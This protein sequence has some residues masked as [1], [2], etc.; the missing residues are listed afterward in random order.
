MSKVINL[1]ESHVG[2]A[3]TSLFA[4]FLLDFLTDPRFKRC[5]PIIVDLDKRNPDVA[6]RYRSTC[7]TED[8]ISLNPPDHKRTSSIDYLLELAYGNDTQ[9]VV[10]VPSGSIDIIQAFVETNDFPPITLRRWFVSNLD[11][12]SWKIFEEINGFVEDTFTPIL[13][14]NL[15]DGLIMSEEQLEYCS[16]NGITVVKIS[17]LQLPDKDRTILRD[18]P[19]VPLSKAIL[20][21]SEQGQKR[22]KVHSE[23]I[24]QHLF[25]IVIGS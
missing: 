14:H 10:N 18:N 12:K 20:L 23:R 11:A 2:K 25:P 8:R 7:K 9:V 5:D 22:L 24:F 17:W 15:I 21:L 3:G 19:E 1:V 6:T 16:V 4:C 13:V